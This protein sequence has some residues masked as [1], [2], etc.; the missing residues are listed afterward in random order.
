MFS[1][2][3]LFCLGLYGLPRTILLSVSVR[4]VR[5]FSLF[6][7]LPRTL[8][9]ASDY[10]FVRVRPFSPLPFTILPRTLRT[11]SDYSFVRVCPF[12]P[13]PL[14]LIFSASDYTDCLGLFFVRISPFSPLPFILHLVLPRTLRTLSDSSLSVSVRLVRC[15]SIFCLG[16]YGLSRTLLCPCPSV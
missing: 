12:C 4:L 14:T 1:F 2:F 6:S 16:L 10:S 3:T 5:C 8:R 9:T 7:I 13:L 15:F 11:A